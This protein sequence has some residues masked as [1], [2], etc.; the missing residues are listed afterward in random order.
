MHIRSGIATSFNA[1]G[2]REQWQQF[3]EITNIKKKDFFNFL[4][5]VKYRNLNFSFKI[6]IFPLL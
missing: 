4:L 5:L 6:F 3:V 1:L 2:E